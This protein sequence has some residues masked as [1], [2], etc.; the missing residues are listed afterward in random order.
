MVFG[1]YHFIHKFPFI[2]STFSLSSINF[3]SST[4]L[5]LLLFCL[6]L[7]LV[8]NLPFS[9]IQDMSFDSPTLYQQS[10]S[11]DDDGSQDGGR[12]HSK[13]LC[14]YY[15]L[16]HWIGSLVKSVITRI[17]LVYFIIL[18][19]QCCIFV[20]QQPLTTTRTSPIQRH[21]FPT[22]AAA[23]LVQQRKVKDKTQDNWWYEVQTPPAW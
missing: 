18:S 3:R 4:A 22:G 13:I 14:I 10:M 12:F 23:V 6:Y 11:S 16:P 17:S 5:S 7:V 2:D 19:L 20:L 9:I 1:S 8:T 21:C 15:F